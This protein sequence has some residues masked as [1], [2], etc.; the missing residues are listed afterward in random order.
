MCRIPDIREF[1][2]FCRV[3]T[4][5]DR[6]IIKDHVFFSQGEVMHHRFVANDNVGYSVTLPVLSMTMCWT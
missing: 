6:Q 4:E 2:G 3:K 5:R 1:P